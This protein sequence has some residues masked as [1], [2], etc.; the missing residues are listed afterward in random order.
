MK[1]KQGNETCKKRLIISTGVFLAAVS[2]PVSAQLPPPPP[3]P[4]PPGEQYTTGPLPPPPPEPNYYPYLQ[5]ADRKAPFM[6]VENRV[7]D[8]NR[9]LAIHTDDLVLHGLSMQAKSVFEKR[10]A[11]A[12][13][14]A[15]RLPAVLGSTN[16]PTARLVG[17][18]LQTGEPIYYES[19][20]L[21]AAQS[22]HTDDLWPGGG[23]GLNLD[24]T[25][26]VIGMWD[27]SLVRTTH[28]EFGGRV[29]Q[30]DNPLDLTDPHATMVAGTLVA[31]GAAPSVHGMSHSA[32]LHA[33]D[34]DG[35]DGEMASVIGRIMHLSNHSY[36]RASGWYWN[37]VWFWLGDLSVDAFE[38][39]AFGF[40]GEKSRS[41]DTLTHQVPSHLTV[42]SAG[43]NAGFGPRHQPVNHYIYDPVLKTYV[44]STN[45]AVRALNGGTNGFD[46]L[47]P[48][49]SS[50]NGLT[51]GAIFKMTNG[52][53]EVSDVVI[54][55]FS[56]IGGTD[57]GRIKPDLVAPGVDI[58]TTSNGSDLKYDLGSGTSFS[59]PV[60]AGSLN[61]LRQLRN[62]LFTTN[63]TMLG[64]T[65][66][67]LA[68][69]TA[70][71]AGVASGPDYLHGWGAFNAQ[72]CAALIGFNTP[73]KPAT[74]P[75]GMAAS[76]VAGDSGSS[77]FTPDVIVYVS[78]NGVQLV[79]GDGT[80]LSGP[81]APSVF[82]GPA[83][84][85]TAVHG[86]S[87]APAAGSR[88]G[89]Q[90]IK[91]FFLPDGEQIEFSV[92]AI[93]GQPLKATIAWADPPGPERSPSL[94][95]TNIVL[96]NDLDLCLIS[97]SGVTNRPWVL[98]PD[99]P[100]AA[101]TRGDNIRDNVEQIVVA[102][103]EEGVYT[104][105]VSH[106]GALSSGFQHVSM[107]LSGHLPNPWS[108]LH[109]SSRVVWPNIDIL[110]LKWNAIPGASYR[111]LRKTSL[112]DP[113]WEIIGEVNA[114]GDS[115]GV[116]F[117]TY[118]TS[119]FFGLWEPEGLYQ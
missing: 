26:T 5:S 85:S 53:Q 34:W 31:E 59:A 8:W 56:S 6:V 105:R 81:P 106:K 60:V 109:L 32:G 12:A 7:M 79:S 25:N 2:G 101:A 114:L 16:G 19:H 87:V 54:A 90:H 58:H 83:A 80:V 4:L 22:V 57:D 112:L 118:G 93:S 23:T 29:V 88:A 107:V 30:K 48:E 119:A 77:G 110:K 86:Q 11:D 35:D 27:Q 70:D 44:L 50:K 40:Y 96:V 69:H 24:G 52:Y 66:R 84:S 98:D 99:H 28:L 63:R 10:R 108:Q 45:G 92:T 82:S 41:I 20:N 64:S 67:A 95:P 42:W 103:P 117:P 39:Y 15:G 97:P 33:Y 113:D 62:D 71:E 89:R 73:E 61:L 1:K 68:I 46:S 104:V 91:E 13:V 100:V 21:G 43:N 76:E 55:G 102:D 74:A 14:A 65:L 49:A 38:D 17:I 18:G 116:D 111:V 115:A 78:S 9:T 47:T 37:G 3:H 36:G 75:S 51:L 94:N 72:N